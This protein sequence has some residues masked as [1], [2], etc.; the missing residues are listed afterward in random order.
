MTTAT[1][2]RPL[3]G[4]GAVVQAVSQMVSECLGAVL[5]DGGLQRLCSADTDAVN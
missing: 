3:V 1:T 5:S 2:W 4:V